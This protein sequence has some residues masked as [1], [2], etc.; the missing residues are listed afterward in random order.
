MTRV[1]CRV[2]VALFVFLAAS[3]LSA[4]GSPGVHLGVAGGAIFPTENARELYDVGY[5][6]SV[7][8]NLNAP[9]SPIGLRLEG[10]Y[11]RANEKDLAGRSG[12]VQIGAGTVNLV[13][14]PRTVT[15][16]PYFVGGGGVYRVRFS[17]TSELLSVR[18]TQTQTR[19][20]WNAGG[21]LSFP[22]GPSTTMFLEARYTRIDLK[23]NPFVRNHL[24]LVPVTLGF[25][26]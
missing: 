25:I 13:L 1:L 17:E 7:M 14:G 2:R 8:L 6:A 3:A 10:T 4:Q 11:A 20:G 23:P 9:L 15:V 21:G 19:F 16:K 26:F 24:T 18:E 22:L 5:H 12:N